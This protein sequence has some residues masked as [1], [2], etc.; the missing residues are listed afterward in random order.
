LALTG[1]AAGL[2]MSRPGIVVAADLTPADTA[3]LDRQLAQGIATAAGSPTSHSAILAR[4]LGI[5]AAVGLGRTLLEVPDDTPLLLDGDA[6]VVY[7]EPDDELVAEYER[8]A[9]GREEAARE[10]RTRAAEPAVTRDGQPVEVVANIGS[11]DDVAAALAN[12]AEGVGLLRTEFLFLER[13]SMPGEDEQYA[14]YNRIAEALEGRPLVLR[15]LDVGADKP[16]PYLPAQPEAN[17]FLGVRGIRL[18]LARPELLE[19]QLR[20]ALRTSAEH[21]LKV[22]FPMVATLEEYRQARSA[23]EHVREELVQ[24][25]TAVPEELEVG[26]MIEVPAAALVAEVFA[27]EVDFFSLGT[28][29]LTQYTM[30]AER[31][32]PSVA[33]LAD[34]L[35]PAVLRLIRIVAE[36]ASRYERWVGVCGELASDPTAAPVL[37]GLG[38]KELSANAPA[39]PAVKQA[40]RG[41]DTE[42]ARTLADAALELSSAAEVRALVEGGPTEPAAVSSRSGS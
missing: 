3:R 26:V 4:S 41:V 32:N 11:P 7:V 1:E 14:A 17:P 25:G 20:A 23:L 27:P 6:G 5:P 40:V 24:T 29:D 35:H 10:A 30:A 28:N 22:M 9:A 18:A 31:G 19:T 39:I 34:G 38:I 36:A 12:G 37:V 33:G 16:L 2:S 42:A 15:T 21:P 13:D 8:R